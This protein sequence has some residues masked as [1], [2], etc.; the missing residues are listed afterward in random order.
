MYFYE[1]PTKSYLVNRH[2]TA[3]STWDTGSALQPKEDS[4]IA[5]AELGP[6]QG[7]G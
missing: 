4:I 5:F 3:D 2:V 6:C 1:P 7:I